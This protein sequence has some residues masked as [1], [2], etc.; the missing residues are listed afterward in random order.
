MLFFS[1]GT[2]VAP[3]INHLLALANYTTLLSYLVLLYLRVISCPGR[4]C[5]WSATAFDVEREDLNIYMQTTVN[6]HTLAL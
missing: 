2:E 3:L 1:R 4:W 6:T 5:L